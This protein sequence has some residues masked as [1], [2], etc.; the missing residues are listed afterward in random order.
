MNLFLTRPLKIIE[1]YSLPVAAFFVLISTAVFNFFIILTLI[2]GVFRIIQQKEY[3]NKI[4]KKFM[5]YGILIFI[6]LILSTYYTTSGI[7]NIIIT[8]KKYI[9]FLYLPI[10]YF[11]IKFHKN[12]LIIIKYLISG[13][14]IILLLSYLQFFGIMNFSLINDFFGFDLFRTMD[15]AS[16][17][18]TS[19]VHGVVFSLIFYISFYMA[20]K[21]KSGY[22]ISTNISIFNSKIFFYLY[23]LLCLIN[24]IMMNDSRNAYIISFLLVLL[25]IYYAFIKIKYLVTTIFMFLIFSFSITD[26]SE[27]IFLKTIKEGYNDISLL[28]NNDYTSSIG[29]RSLWIING[30]NNIIKEPL[31]GSGVGSY[32]NTIKDFIDEKN[33]N[34][35]SSL[36]ISNNPHN[37]YVSIS[38]QLGVFGLF[39]YILF[40]YSLYKESRENMLARGVFVIIFVSSI[41]N[42]AIYDNVLG[43]FIILS[44]SL[45]YQKCFIGKI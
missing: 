35:D 7:E 39:I 32:E 2:F 10:L 34:V 13:S 6:F 20:K 1:I 18:Q 24:V 3:K 17:F 15:K 44:I 11:Y 33:I 42:S 45:F 8:L 40:M 41:F 22:K 25:L 9:K 27:T 14:M 38:T 30:I 26:I 28:K 23:S 4:S 5:L 16:V 19:I 43:L 29:L 12:H 36:A 21:L 37:E 31:F